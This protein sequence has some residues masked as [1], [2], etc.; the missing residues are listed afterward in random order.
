MKLILFLAVC[1]YALL[2]NYCLVVFQVGG[3]R[4]HKVLA[5][6]TYNVFKLVVDTCKGT[7]FFRFPAKFVVVLFLSI[8]VGKRRV[9]R[10]LARRGV[11]GG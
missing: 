3:G 11:G 10:L 5:T 8:L 1:I 9:S 4:L 7:F 6:V 2:E